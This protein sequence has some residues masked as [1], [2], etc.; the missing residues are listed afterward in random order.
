MSFISSS[1]LKSIMKKLFVFLIFVF[2]TACSA[3][4]QNTPKRNIFLSATPKLTATPS[5]FPTVTPTKTV[6]LRPTASIT[7]ELT[8]YQDAELN[9][10]ISYPKSWVE[11][12]KGT[13]VGSDGYLIIKKLDQ[14]DSPD[15]R[16]VAIDFVNSNYTNDNLSLGCGG[17]GLGCLIMDNEFH[18]G[19]GDKNSKLVSVIPYYQDKDSAKYFSM[20]VTAQYYLLIDESIKLDGLT[21]EPTQTVVGSSTLQPAKKRFA[22]GISIQ[23][24]PLNIDWYGSDYPSAKTINNQCGI[25]PSRKNQDFSMDIDSAGHINVSYNHRIIYRYVSLLILD[26]PDSFCAWDDNWMFETY[27]I[28][29]MNGKVLNHELGYDEIFSWHLLDDKPTFFVKNNGEYQISF[30]GKLIPL[31]YDELFH[32]WCISW[33]CERTNSKNPRTDGIRTWFKARRGNTWFMVVVSVK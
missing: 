19:G 29:V 20:E 21:K 16:H 24:L 13:F 30:D 12:S 22:E 4:V 27:D 10:R 26:Q 8:T 15:L 23:E 2:L 28:V 6:T 5:L 17:W 11:K 7:P 25:D 33:A 18:G 3:A 31:A 32:N 9:M 14:Y 1:A